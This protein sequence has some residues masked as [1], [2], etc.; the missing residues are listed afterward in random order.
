MTQHLIEGLERLGM[1]C[2][3]QALWLRGRR[4]HSGDVRHHQEDKVGAIRL[5]GVITMWRLGAAMHRAP[6]YTPGPTVVVGQ[7]GDA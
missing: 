7:K 1:W 2:L 3:S 5:G 4:M 6:N